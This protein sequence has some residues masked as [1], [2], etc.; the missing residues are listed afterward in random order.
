MPAQAPQ[1]HGH[2]ISS[3]DAYDTGRVDG[4]DVDARDNQRVKSSQKNNNIFSFSGPSTSQ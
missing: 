4:N 3:G 2:D 1:R